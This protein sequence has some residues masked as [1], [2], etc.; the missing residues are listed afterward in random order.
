MARLQDNQSTELKVE[1]V[2]YDWNNCTT[3]DI[4]V[5]SINE[6]TKM[7]S[8]R[9]VVFIYSGERVLLRSVN[10]PGSHKVK[11]SQVLPFALEEEIAEELGEF[12]ISHVKQAGTDSIPVAI[13]N[14]AM[15]EQFIEKMAENNIALDYLL[16]EPLMLPWK[17]GTLSIFCDG[18]SVS[19]RYGRFEGCTIKSE[20]AETVI[21]KIL[22]ES[23]YSHIR[24]ACVWGDQDGSIT[25]L[26]SSREIGLVDDRNSERVS[27]SIK[28]FEVAKLDKAV[29]QMNLLQG[30]KRSTQGSAVWAVPKNYAAAV[31]MILAFML[32]VS[33][34]VYHYL[35]LKSHNDSLQV[36]IQKK[37]KQTFPEVK[38]LVDPLVQARQKLQ[39]L[40]SRS[41]SEK[42]P[43]MDMLYLL[44]EQVNK[45]P[46]IILNNVQFA[47]GQ[48][49]VI[50]NTDDIVKLEQLAYRL[51]DRNRYKAEVVST[52][53]NDGDIQARMKIRG[54]Q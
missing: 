36:Q 35:Q 29:T 53:T 30:I 34:Q 13:T 5:S 1:W 11:L 27:Q 31:I 24:K 10:I 39:Q 50:V 43:F 21:S 2:N 12:H 16:P 38:R 3:G 42:D 32:M 22:A 49:D 40:R 19:L 20:L 33:S 25:R 6:F 23:Q 26:L 14:K 37:F 28:L 7:A 17:E 45:D 54:M 15:L 47:S 46:A 8:S 44:G 41:S 18:D 9:A 52:K 51:S 4:R 48:M